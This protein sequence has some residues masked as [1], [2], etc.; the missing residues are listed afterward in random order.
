MA[1]RKG[2]RFTHRIRTSKLSFLIDEE[3][4][5][6]YAQYEHTSTGVEYTATYHKD[7]VCSLHFLFENHP[8]RIFK[9]LPR[10]GDTVRVRLMDNTC[11]K[12]GVHLYLASNRSISL[13]ITR[14][15]KTF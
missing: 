4:T 13:E 5:S 9:L 6:F 7:D 3:H 10:R 12:Y 14:R 1:T 8:Q 15:A 2:D 11:V